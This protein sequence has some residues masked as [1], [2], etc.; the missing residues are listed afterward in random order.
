MQC[1]DIPIEGERAQHPDYLIVGTSN[2]D[3]ILLI[4]RDFELNFRHF[5]H[6]F[7]ITW[8]S[9]SVPQHPA[10]SVDAPPQMHS[11]GDA[12]YMSCANYKTPS[13]DTSSCTY[14]IDMC[15]VLSVHRFGCNL[16][17]TVFIVHM[18][19]CLHT[20]RF[21]TWGL[22]F[23]LHGISPPPRPP[24]LQPPSARFRHHVLGTPVIASSSVV[25]SWSWYILFSASSTPLD[26]NPL[27]GYLSVT[28]RF[29]GNDGCHA[30]C[31]KHE[32]PCRKRTPRVHQGCP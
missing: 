7:R 9:M 21:W 8:G 26:R 16:L 15:S 25:Y 4:H 3:S 1:N 27:T 5:E 2:A 28:W 24:H 19:A 23:R 31:W 17:S 32:F 14:T 13:T 30:R 29:W 6:M 12:S 10:H 18:R 22:P 11:N 20:Q